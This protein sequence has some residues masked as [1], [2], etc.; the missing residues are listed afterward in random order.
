ML[1]YRIKFGTCS[2][3]GIACL[4]KLYSFS[5]GA[6]GA[7]LRREGSFCLYFER[8]KITEYNNNNKCFLGFS[9]EF[10][11]V[12][13]FLVRN[14]TNLNAYENFPLYSTPLCPVEKRYSLFACGHL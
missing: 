12:R 2:G 5:V 14:R 3:T 13:K 11:L 7:T 1:S 4:I 10:N 8:N 9:A 6:V